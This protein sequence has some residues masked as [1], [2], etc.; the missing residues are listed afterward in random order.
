MRAYLTSIGERTTRVCYEQ[1]ERFGFDV[2]LLDKREE[3][4]D[5]YKSFIRLAN[6]DCIRIDADIIP[7]ES[8]KRVGGENYGLIT[9]M[10]YDLYRNNIG[11]SSPVF[12]KKRIIDILKKRIKDIPTSRPEANASRFP[13][14]NPDKYNSNLIIGMHGFFQDKETRARAE[15]N[16]IERKQIVYYDFNLIKELYKND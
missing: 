13:E 11:V 6:E 16:K 4:V 9:Y 14:I 5:K 7:N 3:W 1:L 2:I 12:Y 15:R 10:T 8:I